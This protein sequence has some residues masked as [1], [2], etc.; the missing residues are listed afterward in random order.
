MEE[1]SSVKQLSHMLSCHGQRWKQNEGRVLSS[2]P[3]SRVAAE[4]ETSNGKAGRSCDHPPSSC[5]FLVCFV[6]SS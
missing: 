4:K 3:F 1:E 5:P 6:I 2:C